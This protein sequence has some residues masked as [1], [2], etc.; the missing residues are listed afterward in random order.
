MT[1]IEEDTS[2]YLADVPMTSPAR[3]RRR[4]GRLTAALFVLLLLAGGFLAG[5]KV[6]QHE[7]G[8]SG[9]TTNL[10]ALARAVRGAS[11]PS[12]A[13]AAGGPA[14]GQGAP[15]GGATIGSVR[16]VDGDN[17]YV[18]TAAGD[19]IKVHT[20]KNSTT[21]TKT[22]TGTVSDIHP[23]DNVVVQGSAGSDGT[24]T[25]T[26]V[27]DGGTAGGGGGGGGGGRARGAGAA[28]G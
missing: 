10:A 23:G 13:A 5:V 4:F 9:A 7:G 2:V 25:A 22:S 20:S 8:S 12:G 19:I 11:G 18:A 17:I 1:T 28:G 14:Q 15:G 24:V 26:R 6:Q 3:V 16:L 21:I 27:N